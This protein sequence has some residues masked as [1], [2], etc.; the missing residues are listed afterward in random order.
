MVF[1]PPVPPGVARWN[2]S[3]TIKFIGA[4]PSC[5]H[6]NECVYQED[7]FNKHLRIEIL[8]GNPQYYSSKNRTINQCLMN[9]LQKII[10]IDAGTFT[11]QH[12]TVECGIKFF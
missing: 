6:Q 12:T 5:I 8:V 2:L 7:S 4:K 1:T 3:S 11:E 10:I 9:N